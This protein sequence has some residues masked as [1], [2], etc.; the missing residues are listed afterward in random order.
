MTRLLFSLLL[1][2]V[3]FLANGQTSGKE[4][5][6]QSTQDGIW[7]AQSATRAVVIGI[8]D[9]QDPAIP[10]LR[11]ANKDAEAFANFL[12]S[13]AGGSLDKDHLQMLI[14]QQATAGQIAA[15]FDW[16][17][18]Q[19]KEGDQAIIYF[20]GHGDVERKTI[21]QPGFLLCWDAPARVYMG[22]GTYS[23][24]FLQEIVT[25]LSVQNKAKVVVV[26]DACHAGKLAG[27]Q[28]GGAQATAANLAKQYANEVKILSCQ[29]NE[30]SLEGE[31]WGGGRG[32]FSYHLV[33]ALYGL[34]DKNA[35]GSISLSEIDR[36]L[37]DHVTVE[38]A[39]QSQMP[40]V[41][42]NKAERLATVNAGILANLQKFKSEQMAFFA[43]TEGKGLEEE[44][45]ANLDSSIVKKYFAFKLALKEKRFLEPADNCAEGFYTTLAAEP[46]LAPLHGFLKRSYAAALQ[47]DAQQVM[48]KWLKTDFSEGNLSKKTRVDKYLPYPRYLERAAE[49]LGAEHYMYPV[50]QSRLHFFKG[51]LLAMSSRNP[52]KKLGEQALA[53][54]RQSLQW[55]AEMPQAYWKMSSV[56]AYNLLQPD[57]AE[58][59]A[60]RA[61]ELHPSWV[62]PRIDMVHL[63]SD[64]YRQFDRAKP[65][66]EQASRLDSNSALVCV[67]WGVYFGHQN[68]YAEA[69][70]QYKKAIQLDSTYVTAYNNLGLVYYNT[71]RNAEAEQQF[72]KAIELDSTAEFVYSNLGLI[73]YDTRRY[74]EAEHQFKTAIQIDSTYA[75]AYHNLGL[76]YFDTHRYAEAEQQ[77]K[78]AIQLD[79]TYAS[80]YGNLGGVYLETRRY[81]EAEQQFKKVVQ[82]DSTDAI[83]FV[84]LFLVYKEL[85]R[86]ADAEP[87]ILKAISFAPKFV[88]FKIILGDMYLIINRLE[89][90]ERAYRE[91]LALAPD[92]ADVYVGLACLFARRQQTEQAWWHLEDACKKGF[93]D[94]DRLQNDIDLAPLRALPQWKPLMKKHFPAQVK[95]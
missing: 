25:T 59:Y 52:D 41:L 72:K 10:D 60:R 76:V 28:I 58:Q 37:E 71:R 20:S 61:I 77:F 74:V 66:L 36:Y 48:N 69:E 89:D 17:L 46:R 23:L 39:P 40:M 4:K 21:S 31:Q 15:A 88:G 91:E 95:D 38:A 92:F 83:A 54:F 64:K 42:G 70:P 93:Q 30:F 62:L 5:P 51:Y 53:Q 26:T 68:K 3:P 44:V 56:F 7:F 27:S 22:G 29:P 63:F 65:Y 12:H 6:T 32:V 78:N 90:A 82:L 11:F 57:S 43:S 18:E 19:S 16:L 81:A 2:L 45:L 13:P 1:L 80:A 14:N 47:D 75:A 85:E 33:D 50:L 9:Y 84:N 67:Y 49:L 79:S 87:M 24:A 94:Y 73:Y 8:S 86:Y 34:A 55:Q 35:D